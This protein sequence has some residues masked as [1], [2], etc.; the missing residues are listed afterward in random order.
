M[1]DTDSKHGR[2]SAQVFEQF[3]KLSP[4]ERIRAVLTLKAPDDQRFTSAFMEEQIKLRDVKVTGPNR[5]LV[6]FAFRVERS[7]CNQSGNLH[8][9]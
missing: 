9:A 7:Y 2:F 1:S 5:C 4:E 3:E 8:G 6:T